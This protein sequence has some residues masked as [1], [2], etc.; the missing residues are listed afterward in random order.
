MSVIK[1]KL[2][3]LERISLLNIL[4]REGSVIT[5]R[6]MRELQSKLSF[7]EE[8]LKKYRMKNTQSPDGRATITWDEDFSLEEAD[9]EI[10]EAVTGIIV[11]EL[12][13][14]DSQNKLRM[15]ALSLYEKFVE[16]TKEVRD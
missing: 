16:G 13:K 14:L 12:K 10:G 7:T 15:E 3:I 8:E 1:L 6:I 5:L 4:P 9:I 2:S 11:K